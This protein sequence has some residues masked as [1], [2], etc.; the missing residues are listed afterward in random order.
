M[1]LGNGTIRGVENTTTDVAGRNKR[2]GIPS[3][4]LLLTSDPGKPVVTW[5][6]YD[7]AETGCYAA[8]N[9]V[10]GRLGAAARRGLVPEFSKALSLSARVPGGHVFRV[11]RPLRDLRDPRLGA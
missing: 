2:P 7:A 10:A 9:L 6:L 11:A 8:Y 5:A 1:T 4:P 3:A